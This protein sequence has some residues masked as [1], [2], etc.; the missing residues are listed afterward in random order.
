MSSSSKHGIYVEVKDNNIDL[1]LKKFKKKIKDSALLL[2]LKNREYFQKPSA[3]KRERNKRSIIR[4]QQNTKLN[5][6]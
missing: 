6:K 4:M 2:E 1:A 3:K 5:D